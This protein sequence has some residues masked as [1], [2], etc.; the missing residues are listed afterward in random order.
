MWGTPGFTTQSHDPHT[1][2]DRQ[3][4][5]HH[6]LSTHARRLSTSQPV[7]LFR[8]RR[9]CRENDTIDVLRH[10]VQA[11]NHPT[12]FRHGF[13][14]LTSSA[15]PPFPPSPGTPGEGWGV[16]HRARD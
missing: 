8:A 15:A 7:K 10:P 11:Y 14:L 16:G 3:P 13:A 5:S 12:T 4:R 2:I 6:L 1:S 9:L